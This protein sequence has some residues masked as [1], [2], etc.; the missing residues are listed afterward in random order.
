MHIY[1]NGNVIKVITCEQ[2]IFLHLGLIM[3]SRSQW[4]LTFSC[5]VVCTVYVCH[6]HIVRAAEKIILCPSVIPPSRLQSL[7]ITCD[8][9]HHRRGSSGTAFRRRV[10]SL[11][12]V[13]LTEE[14]FIHQ[15]EVTFKCIVQ[16]HFL[17]VRETACLGSLSCWKIQPCFIFN[18][19][20]WKFF[21]F[22]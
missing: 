2:F 18:A 20:R 22:F 21:F 17:A 16:S 6:L 19:Q 8:P 14:Q 3:L 11:S 13:Q 7:R 9:T 5:L 15:A 10:L 4:S 1:P 12:Q